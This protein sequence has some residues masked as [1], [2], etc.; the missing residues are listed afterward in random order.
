M[1]VIAGVSGTCWSLRG[2][3]GHAGHCGAAVALKKSVVGKMA[4]S[5]FLTFASQCIENGEKHDLQLATNGQWQT[6]FQSVSFLMTLNDRSM[7][8][9]QIRLL[10]GASCVYQIE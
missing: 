7:P 10:C 6:A 4:K 3:R 2:C 9:Y 5:R 1:L 8:F